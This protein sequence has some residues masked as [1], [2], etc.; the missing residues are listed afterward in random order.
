[1]LK[2]AKNIRDLELRSRISTDSIC[3]KNL[4]QGVGH[5]L[6]ELGFQITAHTKNGWRAKGSLS[7]GGLFN[8]K[9]WI[10]PQNQ[11]VATLLMQYLSLDD[12]AHFLVLDEFDA[13][14]YHSLAG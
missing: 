12:D 5:D 14:D 1:M 8:T 6:S 2:W 10:H 13:A 7:W 4:P 11:I 3:A 9:F